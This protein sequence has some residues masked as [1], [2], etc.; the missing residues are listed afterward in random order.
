VSPT[1]LAGEGKILP[2]LR[3]RKA[4]SGDAAAGLFRTIRTIAYDRAVGETSKSI[5]PAENGGEVPADVTKHSE[6]TREK[7]TGTS[8]QV[9][10]EFER[11]WL[12]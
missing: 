2:H 7:I 4:T 9:A 5:E 8:C 3:A 12:T 1:L 10:R 11:T 6:L